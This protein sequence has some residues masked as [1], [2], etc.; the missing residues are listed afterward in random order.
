[1]ELLGDYDDAMVLLVD[2]AYRD[3]DDPSLVRLHTH[4]DEGTYTA[5]GIYKNDPA[6]RARVLFRY[7]SSRPTEVIA[8]AD[9]MMINGNFVPVQ[10]ALRTRAQQLGLAASSARAA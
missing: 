5:I 10:T 1:M 4:W 9:H 7:V 3:P 2:F 8:G 6:R